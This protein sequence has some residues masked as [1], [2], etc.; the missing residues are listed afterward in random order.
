VSVKPQ[1][2]VQAAVKL[3]SPVKIIKEEEKKIPKIED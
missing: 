2:S 1:V 3:A